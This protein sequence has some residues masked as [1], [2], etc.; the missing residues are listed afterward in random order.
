MGRRSGRRQ[1]YGY[2]TKHVND[3]WSINLDGSDGFTWHNV[4]TIGERPGPREA[5]GAVVLANR[6]LVIHG[7]YDHEQGSMNSTYVLDT[8]P[9]PMVW[10]RPTLTG[11]LPASRHGHSLL[12]LVDEEA[13]VFGGLSEYGFERDVSILQVGVG[14]AALYEGLPH[15]LG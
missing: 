15:G 11:A 7:G 4:H 5:H 3:L 14:N 12:R 1:S 2:S 6:Y 10:T 9:R 8:R 13:L